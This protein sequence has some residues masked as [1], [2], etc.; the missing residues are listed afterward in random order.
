[1]SKKLKSVN[2]KHIKSP[3]IAL[4]EQLVNKLVQEILEGRDLQ[5]LNVINTGF[6]GIKPIYELL[7]PNNI[8]DALMLSIAKKAGR[9]KPNKHSFLDCLITSQVS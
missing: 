7:S 1:M 4:D 5:P 6:D 2:V 9:L 8:K 3:R